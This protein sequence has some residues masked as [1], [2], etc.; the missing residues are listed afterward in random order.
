MKKS[1]HDIEKGS[2]KKN[3]RN[4]TGLISRIIH[5]ISLFHKKLFR[6]LQIYFIRKDFK[7]WDIYKNL[8]IDRVTKIEQTDTRR[9]TQTTCKNVKKNLTIG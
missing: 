9:A 4:W 2:G 3:S 6:Y 8:S 7:N 5:D 1:N